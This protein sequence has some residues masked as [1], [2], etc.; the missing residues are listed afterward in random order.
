VTLIPRPLGE[1]SWPDNLDADFAARKD[2][3]RF[4]LTTSRWGT[5]GDH[6]AAYR[7]GL[8]GDLPGGPE[9]D[10]VSAYASLP[11]R[12]RSDET[13]DVLNTALFGG[14]LRLAEAPAIVRLWAEDSTPESEFDLP[15]YRPVG[16]LL[17]G[18]EPLWKLGGDGADLL[19]IEVRSLANETDTFAS[20]AFVTHKVITGVRGTRVFVLFDTAPAGAAI[21]LKLTYRPASSPTDEVLVIPIGAEPDSFNEGSA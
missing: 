18:P 9:A 8:V 1:S 10:F 21:A 6:I 11:V 17:D 12:A 3:F 7:A 5:F 14:P 2:V 13:V 4:D 15:T 16:V 19:D 20:G